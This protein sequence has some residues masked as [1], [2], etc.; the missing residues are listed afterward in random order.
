MAEAP[1]GTV[2]LLF[3]DIEGSTRLWETQPT[4][5]RAALARHDALMRHCISDHRG[6]LFK[7]GGDAFYAAFHTAS[8]A[9]SAALAA[10]RA[11]H[12]E[13]WPEGAK[14]R[15]RMALHSGA[16]ELRDADYFG[17]PLNRVARLLAAAHG[18]QTLVSESTRDL[19]RDDLPPLGSLN[20]LGVHALKDLARPEAVF[21]L[22]HPDLPQTFPPLKSRATTAPDKETPSIAVLP[23]INMSPNADDEYF[24]DGLAEELL[25]V[26]TK[27]RGLRVAARSSAFTFKGKDATVGEVGRALNVATVLEGSVRKAGNR[28]RISVQLVKVANGYHVW[29]ERYDRTLDDIFAVQDDIAQSVVTELRTTLLGEAVVGN[30][31]S[32][33]K[34]QVAVA[35]KGRATDAEAYQLY[36]QAVYFIERENREDMT[37]AVGYLKQALKR[38]PEFALAWAELGRAHMSAA[39]HGWSS[40]ATA[41][42]CAREAVASALACEPELAEGYTHLGWIQMMYDWNWSGAEASYVRALALAPGNAAVLRRAGVLHQLLGRYDDAIGLFRRSIEKDP[43]NGGTYSNLAITLYAVGRLEEAAAACRKALELSPQQVYPRVTLAHI[44]IAQDRPDEALSEASLLEADEP[45]RVWVLAIIHHAAGRSTEAQEALEQLITKHAAT[46]AYWIAQ[47]YAARGEI[48]FAFQW[49]ERA[50]VQRDAGLA[51]AKIIPLL[52]PLHVDPR[53]RPF[54]RKMGFPD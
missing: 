40:A 42:E 27:I 45:M 46:A 31:A 7:T 6:H 29:S 50:F 16:V 52:R 8:D 9:V 30:D 14:L 1:T 36:L 41:F 28:L 54:M 34:A 44:L 10:Q 3:T 11:L 23:F 47:V 33:V 4:A 26:L 20:P 24:A 39:G 43:L 53:W 12:R 2:T 32:D 49:L 21:Q 48:D 37:K 18:G 35:V 5:M 17:A 22:C 38:D 19:C 51:H 13:P 25:N 15:V